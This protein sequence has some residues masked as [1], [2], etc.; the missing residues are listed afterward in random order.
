MKDD[1]YGRHARQPKW[2][3]TKMEENRNK[4]PPKWKTTHI[5]R[6]PKLKTNKLEDNQIGI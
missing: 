4:R 2:K 6:C 3:T 1:Q 5:R